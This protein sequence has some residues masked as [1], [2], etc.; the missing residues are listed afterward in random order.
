[1]VNIERLIT[2]V[3]KMKVELQ[4]LNDQSSAVVAEIES[5]KPKK[6]MPLS[7]YE[8]QEYWVQM[9]KFIEHTEKIINCEDKI[10]E[11]LAAL[12][13]PLSFIKHDIE[14]IYMGN[15][16]NSTTTSKWLLSYDENTGKVNC[17]RV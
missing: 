12:E 9:N 1:M 7:I 11:K 8:A 17:T 3:V 10:K 14:F 2:E 4:D 6:S 5:Q 16:A 13:I 15:S